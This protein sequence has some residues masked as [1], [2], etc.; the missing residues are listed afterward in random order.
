MLTY[1]ADLYK[2][3]L[4]LH[5]GYQEF[6][7]LQE[8][9]MQSVCGNRDTLALMPTGGGKSI[10]FQVP[11]LAN[12]GLC[13]VITPLISLMKDQVENLKR[14]EIKA[15]AVYSGMTPDEINI[16]FEN[17]LYGGYKFLYI[18]PERLGTDLFRA[19]VQKMNI[20]L[21]AVDEAHCISQWGY[22]FRPSYLR[23][24]DLRDILPGVPLLAL[25][26]TATPDV[27]DDIQEKLRFEKKN[28]LSTSFER[29]NLIYFVKE[30]D[31]KQKYLLKSIEKLK[32]SGIVYVRSRKRAKEIAVLLK[33]NKFSADFY[34]A[35]LSDSERSR[36]QAEWKSGKTRIIV[37]TNAF[38]MGIDKPDVRFV[39]HI[40][41]PDTLEEYF[42]EAGRAGRD[43]KPSWAVL[44]Y[45]N[46][47]KINLEKR[48]AVNFPE[49]DLIKRIY[50]ALGNY[51][52][53]PLGGGKDMAFDFN[54]ATFSTTFNFNMI[55]VYNSLKFLQR[56]GYLELTDDMN[57]PS[58]VHFIVNRDDLYKFQV[59][60]VHFDAFIKLLLRT[61]SG[62]F[63]DY[64][65][66]YEDYLASKTGISKETVYQYLIKLSKY[67][68]I[69]YIPQKKTS[70]VVYTEERLDD[71]NLFISKEKYRIRKE[72]YVSKIQKVI[73]Y[74]SGKDRCRS[75][76]LLDYFGEKGAS[77]CGKC[78]VC[79]SRKQPD[80][81]Q[82][83]FDL[84]CGQIKNLLLQAPARREDIIDNLHLD[85]EKVLKVM[86]WLLDNDKITCLD[87]NKIVWQP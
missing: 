73:D 8:K 37:S 69:N 32:G 57:N 4:T 75:E 56:E 19:R 86:D 36:R 25:T 87:D 55:V 29:K 10:T 78:D 22:D 44:L 5:W 43:G 26:A 85:E 31:D 70:L 76:F 6:R 47:D 34:H 42:Q 15:I 28:V 3:I 33:Q 1:S 52:Q 83:E 50:Q 45:N 16:A 64:T 74:A 53:I 67:Q 63:S 7:P 49:T 58:K 18:S 82:P 11:V 14:R 30:T 24:A 84:I 27:V 9:V 68:V 65:A 79:R 51:F 21:I 77:S 59:A 2:Q 38:G 60:N 48:I 71:K 40:D 80:M 72:N 35:G 81:E 12:E 17:C 20:N 41:L 39:L 46:S 61:Y 23:I 54:L 13:L 62:M 66:I